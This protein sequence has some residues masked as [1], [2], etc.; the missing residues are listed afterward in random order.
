[1]YEKARHEALIEEDWDADR[2]VRV[3]DEIVRDTRGRFDQHK[4]WPIHPLDKFRDNLTEPLKMLYFGAAGVIWALDYLNKV[5]ATAVKE[6]YSMAL[7]ELALKNRVEMA[8]SERETASYWMG[9]VGILLVHWR[10]FPTDVLADAIHRAV[11]ANVDNPTREFMWG[12]P[13]TML[14]ALFMFEFTGNG[15]WKEAYLQSVRQLVGELEKN[16][17]HDCYVWTQDLYGRSSIYLGAGHGLA[18]NVFSIAKGRDFLDQ[19]IFSFVTSR[20][21]ET[22]VRTASVDQAHA[23]WPAGLGGTKYLV[24]H[25]HGAPGMINCLADFPHGVNTSL[26]RLLIQGGELTWKAG[27]LVKGSNLCHGTAGNGYAFLKLYQRTRKP[28]W[29][30]RARAFA[31]HAIRQYEC[32]AKQYGQLRYSLW[33]GD[34]GLAVYLWDCMRGEAKFPT[35]DIF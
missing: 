35:M 19:Q 5:G 28:M 33:T 22:L 4:L 9:D 3:I 20:T 8:L 27:P 10:L 18:A 17:E 34:L 11:L 15:R 13:G 2:V 21:A 12:A 26:D 14:A 25:C 29:L 7:N 30:E 1:M 6:D 23:N 32:H 31:M 24:Q 16:S